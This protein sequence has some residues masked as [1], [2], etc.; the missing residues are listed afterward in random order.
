MPSNHQFVAAE[1]DAAADAVCLRR[2]VNAFCTMLA[3]WLL[4][5]VV[6][7]RELIADPQAWWCAAP[8]SVT[9]LTTFFAAWAVFF[10]D[11]IVWLRA[12]RR[13]ARTSR[14]GQ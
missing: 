5:A 7:H 3:G 10:G 8:I 12:F 13:A 2:V 6:V 11:R 1:A 14:R 9:A 4:Y